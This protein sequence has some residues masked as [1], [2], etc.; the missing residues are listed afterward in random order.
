MDIPQLTPEETATYL[1][2]AKNSPKR[3]ALKILHQLGA[4]FNQAI[5]VV[6]A[7]SYMQPHRHPDKGKIEEIWLLEG[8]MAVLF[9]DDQGAITKSAILE[10]NENSYI[11]IPAFAWHTYVTLSE[12]S[13][14]YET[15]NGVYDPSTW[16]EFADWAPPEN[17]PESIPY[18]NQLKQT[19]LGKTDG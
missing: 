13:I 2:S 12:H 14:S 11:K 16:K 3:R 19:A 4:I 6:L 1:L 7:D 18:L 15:M 9:F 17:T 10:K 8:R 5:N